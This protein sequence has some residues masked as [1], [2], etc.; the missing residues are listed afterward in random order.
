[1]TLIIACLCTVIW[2]YLILFHGRFW[3]EGPILYPCNEHREHWPHIT[4]IIPARNEAS[5]IKATLD[6]LASQDYPGEYRIILVNDRSDDET[7]ECAKQAHDPHHLIT[8]I[9]GQPPEKGWSGKLWA[10]MQGVRLAKENAPDKDGYFFFTD[11]DITHRPQ[12][13]RALAEKALDDNRQLVSEMVELRCENVSEKLLVPAFVF[14]FGMLYPF[15]KINNPSSSVAGAAG[16]T[17]FIKRKALAESGGIESIKD[18]LIDDC[19]LAKQIKKQGFRI[20]LGHSSLAQSIRPYPHMKDIW[21]MIARTAYVQLHFSLFLL[22][23]TIIAM[24][25]IWEA[26]FL[27]TIFAHG[28]PQYIGLA[29]WIVSM[30][31]YVP[32]LHRFKRSYLWALT[33]PFIGLFY[34]AATIDSAINHYFRK[35]VSWKGRSYQ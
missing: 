11:A 1:M 18:A 32:T 21:D 8:I 4:V 12:H 5:S 15:A 20:Y 31:S 17:M 6:S 13:L 25:L 23:F 28:L 29:V 16:G 30:L 34:T 3:Q 35:G 9:D 10:I 14:F 19:S 26:P 24:G 7:K 33:L 22:L 2:F 27:L